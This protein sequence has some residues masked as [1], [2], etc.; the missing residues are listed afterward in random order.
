MLERAIYISTLSYPHTFTSPVK[1]F[2][3]CF[4]EGGTARSRP[5]SV[6]VCV[7]VSLCGSIS[8]Q[9][10]SAACGDLGA[11]GALLSGERGLLGL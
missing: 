2:L 1:L 4:F 11:G 8:R 9:D 10:A 3:F 5:K 7:C 6:R